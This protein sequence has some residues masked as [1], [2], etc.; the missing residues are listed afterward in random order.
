M[1]VHTGDIIA[2]ASSPTVNPNDSI[3]R[4]PPGEIARRNDPI[5]R[6]QRNRATQDN[7]APGSIFKPIVGLACLEAGLNPNET[8]YNPGYFGFR[9]GGKPIRDLAKPGKYNFQ[10]ALV[11]SSNTYFITNGLKAGIESIVQLG[12]RLHLGEGVGLRTKQETKG[13]FPNLRKVSSNW[14]EGDTANICIGQGK[15]AVTPL[16]M[17]VMTAALANGGKVLWPRL[18]DR[19]ESWNP[20]A[21][22]AS[23]LF[24]KGRIRDELRVNPAN[25]KI[26][27]EAMLKDT[28][29]GGTGAKA[30]VP[31]LEICG[32][33]GTAQVMDEHSR[34]IGG[35]TWFASF[36]PYANPRY[37]VVVMVETEVNAGTGGSLCAPI[38]GNI[39][40]ALLERERSQASKGQ[41]LAKSN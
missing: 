36:A 25:M 23:F 24:E 3:D 30:A 18:V 17:A 38:S 16:Q 19:V 35:T 37:A 32:K 1:D 31:G 40:K 26:L 22:S 2:M 20:G 11:H 5:L 7:Y 4:L 34:V 27:H 6:P 8:I 41:G 15:M 21:D 29:T 28:E 10:D 13:I 12:Q 14:Y 9:S 33:T 39:Y